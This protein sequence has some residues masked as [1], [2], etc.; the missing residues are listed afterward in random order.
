MYHAIQKGFDHSKGEIMAWLNSDDKY[1]HGAFQIV[2]QV[3]SDLEDVEWIIG[4]PSM[5]NH[6][7]LYVKASINRRWS[8]SRFQ[9]GDFRWIQQELVFWKRSLWQKSGCLLN[10]GYKYAADLEL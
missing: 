10:T 3:F 1:H 7:G 4:M 5:Y 2:S 8:F 6:E 9:I